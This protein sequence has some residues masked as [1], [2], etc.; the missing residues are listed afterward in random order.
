MLLPGEINCIIIEDELPASTILEMYISKIPFLH[1]KGKFSSVIKAVPIID[2]EKINLIFLD[3]NLPGISGIHFAR[4][5]NSSIAI[6]FTTAYTD[7]AVEGFELD[8]IDYLLKPISFERFTKAI[9]RFLKYHKHNIT[10]IETADKIVEMPFVFV[11]SERRM[12]KI[13]LD[14]ILYLEAQRNYLLIYVEN[15]V[16]RVYHSIAEIEEKLPEA[17]FIRVH[18]SFLISLTKVEAY[19]SSY[20]VIQ[21]QHIPIGR[22][23]SKV[24]QGILK[25]I[26][27]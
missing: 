8:V 18:R 12:V 24:I 26:V 7:Y 23:Y 11:R 9:N 19:T 2:T 15:E 3:I 16:H 1:L 6:I 14:E 10:Q 13:F 20:I 27:K 5:L 22:L 4:S 21:K 25:T 17:S